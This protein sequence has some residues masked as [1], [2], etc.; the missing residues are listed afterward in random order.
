MTQNF[1]TWCRTALLTGD[2]P[3]DA[4]YGTGSLTTGDGR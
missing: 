2:A 4:E 1:A 3:D